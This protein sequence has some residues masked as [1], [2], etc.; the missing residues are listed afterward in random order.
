MNRSCITVSKTLVPFRINV[1][2]LYI[3]YC[4][5]KK[6]YGPFLWMGLNCLKATELLGGG[7][8][9]FTTMFPEFIRMM[10]G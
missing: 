3:L 1:I 5:V 8:L 10:K 9:L 7:S 6:L 4:I 2:S